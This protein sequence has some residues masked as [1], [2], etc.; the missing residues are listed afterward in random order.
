MRQVR[1]HIFETNS[2]STHSVSI[3]VNKHPVYTC[4]LHEYLDKNDHKLHMKFGEFGWGYD[5]YEDD[6]NKLQYLLTMIAEVHKNDFYHP[7]FTSLEEYY[8]LDDFLLLESIVCDHIKECKGIV[9]ESTIKDRSYSNVTDKDGNPCHMIDIEG[10]ID[11]QSC[12]DY[13]CLNDFLDDWDLTIEKFL[14]NDNVELIID[15]DNS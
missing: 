5:E 4:T 13:Y 6:Y 12:E 10:Y 1:E 11:H 7:D 3:R 14:F 8:M 9:I 15:S 2:S